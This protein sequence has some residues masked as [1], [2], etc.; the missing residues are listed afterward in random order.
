MRS[1]VEGRSTS[2]PVCHT[3]VISNYSPHIIALSL[4]RPSFGVQV[5]LG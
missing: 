2:L 4:T 5:Q 1:L 3:C